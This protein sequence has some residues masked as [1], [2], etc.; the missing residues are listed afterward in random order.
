MFG[1]MMIPAALW[2]AISMFLQWLAG[3]FGVGPEA[4]HGV[5]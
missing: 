3:L 4:S 2:A 1:L 5:G